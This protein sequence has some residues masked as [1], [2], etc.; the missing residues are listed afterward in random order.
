MTRELTA[1]VMHNL[2]VAARSARETVEH[3]LRECHEQA[4]LPCGCG[5][6]ALLPVG[7]INKDRKCAPCQA[8]RELGLPL[9]AADG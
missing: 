2:L 7:N 8:R 6:N 3:A 4:A 5:R 9:P 1:I